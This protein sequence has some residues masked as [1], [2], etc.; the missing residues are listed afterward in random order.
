MKTL[1]RIPQELPP[2]SSTLHRTKSHL[3]SSFL[4]ALRTLCDLLLNYLSP[5]LWLAVNTVLPFLLGLNSLLHSGLL[6][7][8]PL[9]WNNFHGVCK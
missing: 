8:S 3:Q 2:W 5:S 9:V 6:H 4:L 7:E 1:L